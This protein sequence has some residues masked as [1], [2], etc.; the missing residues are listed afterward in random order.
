MKFYGEVDK[1][2]KGTNSSEYPAWYLETHLNELKE[3]MGRRERALSRGEVALD[4][5]PYEK[6]ELAKEK[7]RYEAIL[8]SK[9][10]VSDKER[11]LL[12]K[13]YKDLSSKIQASMFTRSDMMFGTASAHEEA[14]RMVEP[15]IE[16]TAEQIEM[17]ED[18]Q[19]KIVN[20]KTSRKGADK[21]FKLIGKLIGEPT[22]T[23]VLRRDK[24]TAAGRPR[25]TV[26]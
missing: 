3:S 4:S 19:I 13:N 24:V 1:N 16:L 17:A 18:M 6:Q 25:Q 15:I 2:D 20:K 23:E 12:W 8:K 7:A 22:N 10:K 26:A 21:L 11:D 9:P 14:K 5:I